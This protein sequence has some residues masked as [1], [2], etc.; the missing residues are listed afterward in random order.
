MT[1]SIAAAHDADDEVAE[2]AESALKARHLHERRFAD[3]V[4]NRGHDHL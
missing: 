1:A 2:P 3:E 4:E